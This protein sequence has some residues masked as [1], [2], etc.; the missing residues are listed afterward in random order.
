[1]ESEGAGIIAVYARKSKFTGKG[2]SVDNQIKSCMEYIKN[3]LTD[4]TEE[5]KIQAGIYKDEGISG[6][7]IVSRPGMVRLISDVEKGKIKMVV[8]YRLDRVSRSV[9]DFSALLTKLACYGTGFISVN[10]AFDTRTPMGRAMMY[11]ASVFAQLERETITERITDNMYALAKTGRW[12]GGRTPLGFGSTIIEETGSGGRKKSRY[13]LK[14]KEEESVIVKFLYYKYLEL[15]SL[16]KLETYLMNNNYHT[17]DG[18]MYGRYTLKAILSNPVYCVADKTAYKYL[19]ENGYGIYA[20]QGMFDG[21]RGL[22]AYNKNNCKTGGHRVNNAEDWIIAAG[23]HNGI[24]GAETWIKVQERIKR[25]SGRS[26]RYPKTINALL[27]GIVR[28]GRCGSYMRPKGGRRAA[29]GEKRYY[30]QCECK[31]KSRGNLCQVPNIPGNVLD[32]MVTT[33]ISG[34]KEKMVKDYNYLHGIIKKLESHT[35]RK[36][37][38]NIIQYQIKECSSQIETLLD[39]LGKSKSETTTEL[40]LK[41]IGEITD[42]KSRLEKQSNREEGNGTGSADSFPYE[43]YASLLIGFGQDIWGLIKPDRQKDI[44]KMVIKEITWDGKDA[45]IYLKCSQ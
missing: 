3:H 27:S 16:A 9:K 24:I 21:K 1:M 28:C 18:K 23:E 33:E 34:L 13:C 26:Y 41:R 25:N 5:T 11:I 10:E 31:E 12:L 15:G 6:K 39:A 35:D 7:D 44:L 30:Y 40:I 8:C 17:R 4:G 29:G 20:E 37:V 19:K 45:I 38:K 36:P 22:I 2:E 14:E 42:I 32:R 43:M